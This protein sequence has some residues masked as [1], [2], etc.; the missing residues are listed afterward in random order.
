MDAI[1]DWIE[2]EDGR[3]LVVVEARIAAAAEAVWESVGT[4]PGYTAWFVPAEVEPGEGGGVTMHHGSFGD[5][6]GTITAWDPPRRISYDEGGWMGEDTPVP[7][8]STEVEVEDP[9]D[10]APL[11][12]RLT[13]GLLED[14]PRWREQILP[15]REGW[16]GAVR[17][18]REYHTHFAGLP[19]AQFIV[20]VEPGGNDVV[21]GVGSLDD[22]GVPGP[23]PDLAE[24]AGLA[25]V[26]AGRPAV[27]APGV[28]PLA[29][30]VIARDPGSVT[31]RV[32]GAGIYE[33]GT[34]EFGPT[35]M[36]T[37]RGYLYGVDAA[38]R[39]AAE[40]RPWRDWVES[41]LR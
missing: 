6:E 8:W 28:P 39:A 29:G 3:C 15:T 11:V 23:V 31:L 32:D 18:L 25:G 9:G 16:V 4:G 10:G 19:A 12:V 1:T 22:G 7:P 30:T 34:A 40:E 20:Q 33:F 41:L 27:T 38:E 24:A 26:E 21:T 17:M 14:G 2:E 37:V 35:R 36:L 13:S 5:S